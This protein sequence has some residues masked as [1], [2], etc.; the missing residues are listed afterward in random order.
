MNYFYIHP[1][2]EFSSSFFFVFEM[3]SFVNKLAIDVVKD[4]LLT[5]GIQILGLTFDNVE[6][7]IVALDPIKVPQLLRNNFF[8]FKFSH[9]FL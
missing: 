7:T 4:E 1:F 9:F 3:F 6:D 2:S 5:T 8:F